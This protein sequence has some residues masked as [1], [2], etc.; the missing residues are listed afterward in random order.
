[1]DKI[2]CLIQAA[3]QGTALQDFSMKQE[4]TKIMMDLPRITRCFVEY[5]VH[6]KYG[7]ALKNAHML[8]VSPDFTIC[9]TD[10]LF[11]LTHG[12]PRQRQ[13][14][15]TLCLAYPSSFV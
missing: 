14:F 8:F 12:R 13:G 15:S 9:Q 6:K 5:C 11:M 2:F 7:P 4:M 3:L 10:I 1:M